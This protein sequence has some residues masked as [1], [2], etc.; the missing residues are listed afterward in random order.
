MKIKAYVAQA[1]SKD[2]TGGNPAGVVLF[3]DALTEQQKRA[4]AK[5][6]GYAE[7]AFVTKSNDTD[8]EIG[9]F[10]PSEEVQICG[11]ATI[12]SFVVLKYCNLITKSELTIKTKMGILNT[13]L[14]DNNIFM[15]QCRPQF[16]EILSANDLNSCF[17]IEVA[18]KK[19]PIEIGSTGLRD[20]MLPIKNLAILNKMQPNFNTIKNISRKLNVVGIHAFSFD[21]ERIVCR[22]FAPLYDV[23]EESATGTSN[24]VL[25]SYLC[26]NNIIRKNQY[27]FEQGYSLNSPSEIIVN[28]TTSNCVISKV[29]V[30]GQGYISAEEEIEI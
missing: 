20:I 25:A 17:D 11:H 7:T 13:T 12:A 3:N 19:L 16:Y 18:D 23:P 14:Q 5:K 27:I 2:N 30:G 9:Y 6:L 22:N 29:E 21:G 28:L 15:E 26:K 10:T 4:I 1:F 8:F 24:C